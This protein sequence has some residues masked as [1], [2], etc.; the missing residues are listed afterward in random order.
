MPGAPDYWA[1]NT[2]LTTD[3]TYS[4]TVRSVQLFKAGFELS[5]PVIE[6]GGTESLIL[7]FDDLQPNI[8]NLSYTLVHCDAGWKPSDLMP[9]QY[10]EGAYNDYLPSGDQSYNT[11]QP[12]IHY[13]LEVPNAIMRPTRSGNYLLKVYRGS[14]EADLVLTRRFLVYEQGVRIDAKVQASRQVDMRD[15]AQQVDL[16]LYTNN[17]NVQ[18]PFGDIRVVVL[19]NMR[20]D[21]VRT[22]FKPRFVRGSEL[23][24]DFPAEGLFMGGN[25]YRNFDLKNLRYATQRIARIEPGVGQQVYDAYLLPEARRTIRLYNNQQDI[26]GRFLVRNDMVEGDPLGADYV[27]VHFT[28][29]MTDPLMDEVYVYGGLTDFQ[30]KKDYRMNW[31]PA[32]NAYTA[33]AL[34]KQGFYD[35]S[36]VTLPRGATVPDIG[37]IE[38]S[39]YQTENDYLILVYYTDRQQ[40]CDRLVGMRFV[41]SRRG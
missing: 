28:L 13:E 41:N 22:G 36:F 8:E 38:G 10:L 23:V 37:A 9:G 7:R 39:H 5:Q 18:D 34:V 20:W 17:L 16:T 3:H 33:T 31:T 30:C 29:P 26:N 40:R 11:L 19:Q 25:E 15:A 32:E 4:P 21:D 24:Y 14:D 1:T 6:L 27:K 12:F 2:L 35:F